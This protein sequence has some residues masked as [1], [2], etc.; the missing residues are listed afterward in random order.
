MI[1]LKFRKNLKYL[2]LP[3]Q[4]SNRNGMKAGIQAFIVLNRISD[5]EK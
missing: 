3:E 5:P 1:N 2:R 4:T